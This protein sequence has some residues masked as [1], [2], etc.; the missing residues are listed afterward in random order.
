MIVRADWLAAYNKGIDDCA[1]GKP[2]ECDYEDTELVEAYHEGYYDE[3]NTQIL[4]S[5]GR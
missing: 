4:I 5:M 1:D 3:Y 2:F